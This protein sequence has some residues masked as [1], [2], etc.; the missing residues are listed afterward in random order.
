VAQRAA[1]RAKGQS[2]N[3]LVMTATPI[4]RSLALT[5]FGDL[6]LS[7]IEQMPPNRQQVQTQVM[8]PVERPRAHQFIRSQLEHGRQAFIIYPLVEESEKV[9]AKAAVDE[10]ERL[11]QE[12]FPNFR[13][14]LLHG[15]LKPDE[16]ES[17]MA[18]FRAGS[19]MCCFTGGGVSPGAHA[20]VILIEGANV[21]GVAAAPVPRR[22]RR[23]SSPNL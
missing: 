21:S 9:E 17:V 19:M 7:L 22:V 12:V 2:P 23:V 14:G 13:L 16:K 8:R 5:V 15:R 11:Q 1:L 18:R 6:D 3:L 10:F 4:P 20:T